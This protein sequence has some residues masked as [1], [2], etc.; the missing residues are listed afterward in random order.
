MNSQTVRR[1]TDGL[2]KMMHATTQRTMSSSASP[3]VT[4]A[5]CVRFAALS[6]RRGS[7]TIVVHDGR[8]VVATAAHVASMAGK[9]NQLTLTMRAD[10]S[11]ASATARVVGVHATL[12]L[13]VC[14]IV[15][16]SST[17]G[18]AFERAAAEVASSRPTEGVEVDALGE[19]QGYAGVASAIARLGRGSSPSSSRGSV[20]GVT[21]SGTHVMHSGAV[22]TAGMSGG[23]LLSVATGR[24]LGVH[25][26][27][28][29]FYGGERD[30]AVSLNALGA[31]EWS[32]GGVDIEA[33]ETAAVNARIFA[34]SD[35]ALAELA[36]ELTPE[37]R[38]A[39]IL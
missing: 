32:R 20:I 37:Q 6:S 19:P 16:C 27:G 14:E 4:I 12:D 38:A 24:V 26:F 17:T 25:S 2:F 7:G 10:G 15:E 3:V 33:Y 31:I 23:P 29:A 1:R 36:P 18:E 39:W 28:D 30:V 35:V 22:V 9:R 5:P 21:K 8:V 34:S 11:T 13:A